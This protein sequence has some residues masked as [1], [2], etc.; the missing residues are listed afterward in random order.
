MLPPLVVRSRRVCPCSFRRRPPPPLPTRL[1]PPR[2]LHS[3]RGLLGAQRL[4]GGPRPA[5]CSPLAG[6][7]TEVDPV[8][9]EPAPDNKVQEAV[10]GRHDAG[11]RRRARHPALPLGL[12]EGIIQRRRR[13]VQALLAQRLPVRGGHQEQPRG[14]PPAVRQRL[15][16]RPAYLNQ[17]GEL[18]AA[19][20]GGGVGAW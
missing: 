3:T 11:K 10:R 7:T 15:S 9:T 18:V 2:C 14:L 17:R 19:L 20:P 6:P 12:D 1:R 8:C 5:V 13:G 4:I 16:V